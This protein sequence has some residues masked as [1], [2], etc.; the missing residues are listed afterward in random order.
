[1][2]MLFACVMG[3][4]GGC[5][6]PGPIQF[7]GAASAHTASLTLALELGVQAVTVV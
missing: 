7:A 6:S 3:V 2:T 1:M 4:A 5:R